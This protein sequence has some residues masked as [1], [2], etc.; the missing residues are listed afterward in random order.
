MNRKH[1]LI[2]SAIS[3]V[4][5]LTL[6]FAALKLCNIITWAWVWVVSPIWIPCT[7][8]ALIII[9]LPV[10]FFLFVAFDD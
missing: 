4:T 6:I 7:L 10:L 8:I 2:G 5:I 3:F 9:I 1:I